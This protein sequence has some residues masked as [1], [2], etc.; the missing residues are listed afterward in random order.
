MSI[1]PDSPCRSRS[2][3]WS[4]SSSSRPRCPRSPPP[5]RARPGSRPPQRNPALA[6]R[7]A[8]PLLD[9]GGTPDPRGLRAAYAPEA[10]RIAAGATSS[11]SPRR[12]HDPQRRLNELHRRPGPLQRRPV[13]APRSRSAFAAC[14]K[15]NTA[16]S[17]CGAFRSSN[18]ASRTRISNSLTAAAIAAVPPERRRRRHP[19]RELPNCATAR[20]RRLERRRP[21]G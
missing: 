9:V 8:A 19:L 16:A 13:R 3:Y 4:S 11:S 2:H 17:A 12:R 6:S 15:S 20:W 7:R 10:P 18:N 1:P 14:T 21:S 5:P